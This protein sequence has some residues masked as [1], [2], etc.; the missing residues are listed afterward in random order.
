MSFV[1]GLQLYDLFLL[2]VNSFFHFL[3]LLLKRFF[4]FGQSFVE[5]LSGS[6]YVI[7]DF[8]VELAHH[9][10]HLN[11]NDFPYVIDHV[12]TEKFTTL[13]VSA[14][15]HHVLEHILKSVINIMNE[16]TQVVILYQNLIIDSSPQD[17]Q[18]ILSFLQLHI[19]QRFVHIF[20][21]IKNSIS[22]VK[23]INVTLKF[24]CEASDVFRLRLQH[25]TCLIMSLSICKT[26]F[27]LLTIVKLLNEALQT[28]FDFF[29]VQLHVLP[30]LLKWILFL[31]FIVTREQ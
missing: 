19:C 10:C 27:L 7:T 8:P 6:L 25:G 16:V 11:L 26:V 18:V 13:T 9:E 30:L 15:Y 29:L 12:G 2:F 24:A 4:L 21:S 1:F 3:D 31:S 17:H 28:S 22:C 5:V 23:V 14:L 20:L